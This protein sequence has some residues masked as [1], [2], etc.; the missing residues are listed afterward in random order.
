M[1]FIKTRLEC[2]IVAKDCFFKVLILIHNHNLNDLLSICQ[3][4]LNDVRQ[5]VNDAVLDVVD[6]SPPHL[7]VGISSGGK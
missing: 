1:I 6:T 3:K 4:Y 7:R 5:S 2:L